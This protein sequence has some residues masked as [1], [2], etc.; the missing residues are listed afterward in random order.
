M[1][2][3]VGVKVAFETVDSDRR[4]AE[5]EDFAATGIVTEVVVIVA[6]RIGSLEFLVAVTVVV[7]VERKEMF[8]ESVGKFVTAEL[9]MEKP[10]TV[11][12]KDWC[13]GFESEGFA[14]TDSAVLEQHQTDC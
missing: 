6:G 12:R 9:A 13:S 14:C 2:E 10:A 1:V 4:I 5:I 7:V 11:S 8:G 3:A